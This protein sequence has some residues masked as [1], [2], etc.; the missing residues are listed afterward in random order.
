LREE[1]RITF[2]EE[3]DQRIITAVIK[4]FG[5]ALALL[6]PQLCHVTVTIVPHQ[7]HPSR[8]EIFR[9]TLHDVRES[10]IGREKRLT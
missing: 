2:A 8:L 3:V 4:V 7:E 9:Q 1:K 6:E 10:V 5:E